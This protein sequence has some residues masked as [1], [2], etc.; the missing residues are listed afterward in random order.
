MNV[1]EIRFKEFDEVWSENLLEDFFTKVT[2]KNRKLKYSV[3]LTN[4]AE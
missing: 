2:S 1:P 4:S 3:V